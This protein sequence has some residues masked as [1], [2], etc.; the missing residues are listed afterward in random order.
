MEIAVCIATFRR[1]AGLQKLLKSLLDQQEIGDRCGIIVVDN[2]PDGSATDIVDEITKTTRIPIEY[3]VEPTPGISAARNRAISIARERGVFA[4]AFI[5]DD[6]FASPF[7]L[8]TMYQRLRVRGA[9]AVSGPVEPI[10]PS[11]APRWALTTRLFHRATFPD[12]AK[13]DY[14]STANSVLRLEAIAGLSEPFHPAFGLTGGSDTLLYQSLKKRGGTII[15]E[16]A[17]LV[18]EDIPA[19]RLSMRWLIARAYRQG[20]TLARCDRILEQRRLRLGLRAGRGLAQFPIGILQAAFSLIRRD[21]HWRRAIV[22]IAR[23]AGVLAGLSGLTY[24]E[25]QRL[26]QPEESERKSLP[27]G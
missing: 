5:D 11:T 2:D 23:G 17:G 18:Y 22:R 26:E 19:S 7:W 15:W 16:P 4:L 13:L 10:L 14:A 12:G 1:P 9:D 21:D 25:Y 6:E 20:I 8:K 24:D 3:A 27:E